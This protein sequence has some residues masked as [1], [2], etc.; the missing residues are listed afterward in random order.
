MH[1]KLEAAKRE[2]AGQAV[3]EKE[4]EYADRLEK[5]L[6]EA[7]QAK[8]R[9]ERLEKELELCGNEDTVRFRLYFQAAQEDF[10]RMR[11]ALAQ[12]QETDAEM[13]RKLRAAVVKYADIL[14]EV[15][16]PMRSA[17]QS[18]PSREAEKGAE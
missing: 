14:K 9:A 11:E 16:Q 7:G 18:V 15:F 1:K 2:A 4:R 13:S 8:E 17:S 6:A 12:I 10:D 5:V 3:K